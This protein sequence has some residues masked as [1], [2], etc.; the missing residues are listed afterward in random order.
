[1][2]LSRQKELAFEL[3]RGLWVAIPTPF[4]AGGEVD[5]EALRTSVE[6]YIDAL[7]VDGIYCG[8]VMGEFWSMSVPERRRVHELVADTAAGRVD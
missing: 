7:H 4:T 5:E 8:G 6:H 3:V 1:M 2:A